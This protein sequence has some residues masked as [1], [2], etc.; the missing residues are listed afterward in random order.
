VL[1]PDKLASGMTDGPPSAD[2]F[3]IE[4][5]VVHMAAF[6]RTLGLERVHLV[7]QSRGAYLAAR[8]ALEQPGLARTL[9]L[10]NSQTI[11]P[12][13]G[14]YSRQAFEARR[15][16]LF[17]GR[18]ADER[19]AFRFTQEK[20]SFSAAH[21]TDEF[22]EIA[23]Y[24]ESLP[25]AAQTR[26]RWASGGEA[27]FEASLD[28]QKEETLRWLRAGRLDVPTLVCWGRNDPS[29]ILAQGLALFELLCAG[30]PHTRMW[31]V[32]QAG[33]FPYREHPDE[34]VRM[35]TSFVDSW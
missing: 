12:E 29:A 6:I 8:L 20:L 15:K 7:G 9:V 26:Q 13:E 23:A 30:N 24:M 28:A 17:A 10:V 31:I 32:N 2:D 14:E 27:R 34:W 22:V 18:P 4:A 5:Q 25:R 11:A 21:I 35:V 33:H 3:T 1:A 19:G 16:V